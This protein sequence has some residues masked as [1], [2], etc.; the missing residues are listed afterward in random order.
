MN[1]I[2]QRFIEELEANPQVLGI[3]LFGSW[4]RGN[5]RPDSDVDLLVIIQH[6]FK[7]TVEYQGG[8]AFEI[9]SITEQ[10]A[11]EYWQ[12]HPNDAVELWNVAKILFDRNGTMKRLQQVGHEIKERGK[13]PLTADQYAHHKFDIH[14]QLRAIETLA[15]SDP[16]TARMLLSLK[17]S[18]LS[19]LFFDIRQLWTPPP[20]QR[21][22]IIRDINHRLYE[23]IARY[24]EE[25]LLLEQINTVKSIVAIV[26]DR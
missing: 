20:K 8:Q 14:D 3:I 2:T 25:Q 22:G 10:G 1:S 4:A 15:T 16:T 9:I 21:L 23:L 11:I 17:V 19:E 5:N 26:F 24:Y 12:S 18:Q 7:R 6:G 13:N